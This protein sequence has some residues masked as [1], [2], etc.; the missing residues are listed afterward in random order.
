MIEFDQLLEKMEQSF[1]L[2]FFQ[3]DI[4]H[5]Q[6]NKYSKG[7]QE[8]FQKLRTSI[9]EKQVLNINYQAYF[10]KKESFI[11]HPYLLK[12]YNQRWFIIGYVETIDKIYNLALDRICNI[13]NNI[14]RVYKQTDIDFNEYY[15]DCI[16]ITKPENAECEA[17]VVWISE[18]RFPYIDSKPIHESQI[19]IKDKKEKNKWLKKIKKPGE[20]VRFNL[21]INKELVTEFF[22]FGEDLVVLQP[23]NL[24]E[25]MRLK[26]IKMG[27]NNDF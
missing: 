16:G 26:Y 18:K 2:G 9:K 20:V 21:I 24:K 6:Q 17:I 12:Q 27:K 11:I 19:V 5:Y 14:K 22:S 10:D 25:E 4:V 3:R 8:H 13:K 7:T 23:Q 1:K 15:E